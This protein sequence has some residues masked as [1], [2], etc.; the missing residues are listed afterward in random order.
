[1][2]YTCERVNGQSI[3]IES[4]TTCPAFNAE[5]CVPVSIDNVFVCQ[6]HLD[7]YGNIHQ[8]CVSFVSQGTET[9]DADGCCLTCKEITFLIESPMKCLG[10]VIQN[11]LKFGRSLNL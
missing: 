2:K 11:D 1:M 10:K 3:A 5:D 4:K 8:C 6:Y 9:L 7:I